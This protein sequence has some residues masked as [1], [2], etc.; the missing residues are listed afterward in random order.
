MEYTNEIVIFSILYVGLMN[1]MYWREYKTPKD[2]KR[3]GVIRRGT[4]WD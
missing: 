3:K 2:I 4:E 1:W